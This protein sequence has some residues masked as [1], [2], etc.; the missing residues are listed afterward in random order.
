MY[1]HTYIHTCLS[2]H[3]QISS[4]A[5]GEDLDVPPPRLHPVRHAVPGL[6]V[7]AELEV[8]RVPAAPRRG[9]PALAVD[10]DGHVGRRDVM[11]HVEPEPA[12]VDG[13][14]DDP[15][16]GDVVV[17]GQPAVVDVQHQRGRVLRRAE[18]LHHRRPR[19]AAGDVAVALELPHPGAVDQLR[20]STHDHE[21][22]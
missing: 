10:E 19:R 18:D 8:V 21:L 14:V 20:A 1:I 2:M 6:P 7:H 17:V 15:R 13:G 3:A 16:G 12:V 11:D 9:Q 4:A 22:D 5:L